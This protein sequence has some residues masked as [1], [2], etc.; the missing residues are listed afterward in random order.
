MKIAIIG[1]GNLGQSIAKGIVDQQNFKWESLYLTKRNVSGLEDWKTKKEVSVTS[2]NV[3]AVRNSEVIILCVQPGQ[4]TQIL[5]EI[6]EEL[7]EK[8]HLLI[9][10]ITG[11]KIEDLASVI[12]KDV[13]IIRGMANTAISV[14]QSMTCLSANASGVDKLTIAQK[15]FNAL[16]DT[17]VIEEDKMQAATVVCASGIAFWMRLIR[18]TT[19][20]AIQLGFDAP[21]AKNMAIQ[22]CM[23]AA[24]L[25]TQSNG[26]PEQEIDKVTTPK[27]CTIAGLNEMEHQGLSSALIKGLSKSYEKISDIMS[28]S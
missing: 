19:Q 28:E 25:L 13:T 17:L 23:G 26:H 8:K 6:K 10:M 5:E 11:R 14:R 4:I 27:G 2:D 12:N 3:E 7:D 18:A 16:G 1:V 24:S 15:I 21:E 22:T 20:G 9:S